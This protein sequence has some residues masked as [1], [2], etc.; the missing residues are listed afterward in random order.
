MRGKENWRNLDRQKDRQLIE[1][2]R[3]ESETFKKG[4]LLSET[5]NTLDAA[6]GRA[7]KSGNRRRKGVGCFGGFTSPVR[8]RCQPNW[9]GKGGGSGRKPRPPDGKV[10]SVVNRDGDSIRVTNAR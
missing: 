2:Q 3:G 7:L 5:K 8:T 10:G 4:F 1:N 6:G 9:G